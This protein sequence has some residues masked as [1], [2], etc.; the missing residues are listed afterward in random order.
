[1]ARFITISEIS[2][3]HIKSVDEIP[4]YGDCI[5]PVTE[6]FNSLGIPAR[7]NGVCDI[8]IE[9]KKISGSAQR[10]VKGRVLHHGTLLYSCDLG[11]LDGLTTFGKNDCFKTKG[12]LSAISS[13]AN[14]SDYLKNPM[15]VE[16]F[17][18]ALAEKLLP[19]AAI[20]L[21]T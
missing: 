19:F 1:M 18:S 20:R 13:V 2:I 21:S 4:D 14:V 12:T 16:D 3:T 7:Q 15:S 6:A 11:A 9:D 10:V 17:Q 8:A 5:R